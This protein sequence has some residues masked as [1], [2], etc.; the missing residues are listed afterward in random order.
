MD[1][2]FSDTSVT[3]RAPSQGKRGVR[4][5]AKVEEVE[6][7]DLVPLAVTLRAH[8]KK[9]ARRRTLLLEEEKLVQ[10]A[11]REAER[12][13][14]AKKESNARRKGYAAEVAATR[15][16]RETQ[17]QGFQPQRSSIVSS[18]SSASIASMDKNFYGRLEGR[19][20]STSL[21]VVDT[22]LRPK[23]PSRP[24]SYT[25]SGESSPNPFSNDR[26][27][28]TTSLPQFGG[29][30]R[31]VSSSADSVP[32]SRQHSRERVIQH[33]RERSAHSAQTSRSR[34]S[35]T[36]AKRQSNVPPVPFLARPWNVPEVHLPPANMMMQQGP[37][38]A[39]IRTQGAYLQ[40]TVQP[41]FYV[42]NAVP[43]AVL[44]STQHTILPRTHSATAVGNKTFNNSNR[45]VSSYG[46]TRSHSYSA[47]TS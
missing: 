6:P 45:R 22:S 24:A 12:A 5:Q 10:K 44:P 13:E 2:E 14:K 34:K 1:S 15:E 43:V 9:A 41:N 46:P 33:S 16:R 29:S 3:P 37:F 4:F 30:S 40:P 42:P 32:R 47:Q 31:S 39:S 7:D 17:R 21:Q 27:S 20:S 35:S 25:S 38:L 19:R 18:S 11:L 36:S 23:L 28:S 8:Q 26:G